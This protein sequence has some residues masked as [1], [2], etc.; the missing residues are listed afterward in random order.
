VRNTSNGKV[1][2][3]VQG[4]EEDVRKLLSEINEGPKHARVV[5]LE[6]KEIDVK[7]GE[8]SFKVVS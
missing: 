4:K 1:E 6:K 5:K 2:G 3:E 8:E 7:D